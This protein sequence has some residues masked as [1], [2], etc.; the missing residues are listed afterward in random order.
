M[1]EGGLIHHSPLSTALPPN[2]PLSRPT[3]AKVWH[4]S[5]T[6]THTH[7]HGQADTHTLTT[8]WI[9]SSAPVIK[10]YFTP[11]RK[12][13]RSPKMSV[14]TYTKKN[15]LS[16]SLSLSLYTPEEAR[17]PAVPSFQQA[18]TSWTPSKSHRPCTATSSLAA[19]ASPSRKAVWP[20]PFCRTFSV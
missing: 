2:L 20:T 10:P 4:S 16:L 17:A 12:R 9:V 14:R 6:H 5:C 15:Y 19:A 11:H 1:S 8:F 13:D 7:T 18:V 3:Q